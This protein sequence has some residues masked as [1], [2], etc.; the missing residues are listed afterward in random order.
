VIGAGTKIDNLCQIGHNVR[1]GRSCVIAGLSGVAGS[2]VIGD[3][4]RIGGQCGIG[5]HIKIGKG[6]TLAG[7]SSVMN[8][9]PDGATWGG[10]PAQDARLALRELSAIRKLPEWSRRLKQLLEGDPS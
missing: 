8:D 4:A 9:V 10:T 3:G 2:A 1:I 7:T 6:V 5:D